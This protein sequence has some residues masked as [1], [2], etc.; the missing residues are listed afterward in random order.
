MSSRIT[1]QMARTH[2]LRNFIQMYVPAL[3]PQMDD[4]CTQAPCSAQNIT[5]LS[6]VYVFFREIRHVLLRPMYTSQ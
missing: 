2:I 3:G 5:T 4:V 6:E 1:Y